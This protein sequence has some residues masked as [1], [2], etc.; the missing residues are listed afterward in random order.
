MQ[1]KTRAAADV[2]VDDARALEEAGAF[3]VLLEAMPPEAAA[4]VR[5]ALAIPVYGIGAG[6]HVDGQL[7]IAHD[8][9]GNFVGDIRPR[10][11]KRYAEVGAS[12]EDA[13]R[14]Y[15]DDVRTGRFPAAEHWYVGDDARAPESV[16][17]PAPE[18][19]SGPV[20]ELT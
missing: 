9:L 13:F 20:V 19:P 12:I 5:D 14:A 17:E 8:L 1:G 15:A 3:A 6:P 10:F 16:P 11:V 18:P 2:L 4:R 7:L